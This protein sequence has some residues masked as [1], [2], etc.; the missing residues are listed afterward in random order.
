VNHAADCAASVGADRNHKALAANGDEVFLGC[1]IGG[2]LA[3]GCTQAFFNEPLLAVLFAADAAQLGRG[4]VG[5]RAVGLNGALDGLGQRAKASGQRTGDRR[6]SGILPTSRAGGDCNSDCTRP[7]RWPARNRCSSLASSAAPGICAL[8]RVA[9]GQRG[10]RRGWRFAL[11]AAAALAGKLVLARDPL[12]VGRWPERE[13]RI[14]A[15][16]DAAKPAT[17]AQAAPTQSAKSASTTGDGMG[18]SRGMIFLRWIYFIDPASLGSSPAR[19][20]QQRS[21]RLVHGD[22]DRSGRLLSR[23]LIGVR[24]GGIEV[25][26]VTCLK[27]ARLVAVVKLQRAF[28]AR[29]ELGALVHMG[30]GSISSVSG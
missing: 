1:A 9:W 16:G 6:E 4:V 11:Q 25:G 27:T 24:R 3:Q 29:R 23:A 2:E 13:N 15:Q 10:R 21:R 17:K 28:P 18:S 19:W 12:F 26:C 30:L 20:H 22:D 5:Q 7:R 8:A 14:V